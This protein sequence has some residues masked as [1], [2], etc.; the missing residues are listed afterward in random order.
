MKTCTT[1]Q[2]SEPDVRFEPDRNLCL[3]CRHHA[4]YDRRRAREVT[5]G[6]AELLAFA[7]PIQRACAEALSQTLDAPKA[8]ELVGVTPD[9]LRAHLSDLVRVAA[10]R[11]WSPA[12]DVASATP[13]GYHVK[14]TSTY[15]KIDANGNRLPGGQWVKT[16]ADEE[17]DLHRLVQ[18]MAHVSD[19]WQSKASPIVAPQQSVDDLLC[20]YPIGDP[21]LGMYSWAQETGHNWTLAHGERN[22]CAAVDKLVDLAPPAS[23]AIVL[24]L[25]DTLHID[26]AFNTTTG[27]TRQ[28]ADSRWGKLLQVSIRG[29]RRCIDRAL[30]K[31]RLVIV[32][33]EIGNHDSH[34]AVMLALCLAQ[35]YE[36]EPRV[37]VDTSPAKFWYYRFGKCLVAST[38][39]DTVKREALAEIMASDRPAD[40]GATEHR[41]W[42]TG[43]IHHDTVKELR[44]CKVE[45]FRTLAPGDKWHHDSGYRSGR[46]MKMIVLHRQYGEINR[47]TVGIGQ[48]FDAGSGEQ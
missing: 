13:E 15:Y 5:A 8:A 34:A 46:D 29:M 38:H 1:C 32:R 30:E 40:W 17:D 42:L 2:R 16:K 36:R 22:L 18:A 27:G 45:S 4:K 25:G 41:Y 24:P 33:V 31:H 14:G 11:G 39:T 20:V 6:G 12:S 26:N 3:S 7:T 21:H 10:R 43:H 9:V 44:G 28:D 19:T 35:F 48:L 37:Q 47:H 23:T